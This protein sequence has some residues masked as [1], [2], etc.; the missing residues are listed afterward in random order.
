MQHI[1][2]AVSGFPP[3]VSKMTKDWSSQGPMT[4]YP[5]KKIIKVQLPAAPKSKAPMMVY[6]A[7]RELQC[8]ISRDD[9]PAAYDRLTEFIQSRGTFG[10]KAYLAADLRSKDE[11]IIKIDEVLA[12]QRF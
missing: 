9:A 3:P 10:L 8:F 7:K 1:A 4:E 5:K 2:R 11:L 6:D 12:E